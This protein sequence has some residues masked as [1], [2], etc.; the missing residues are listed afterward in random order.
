[1]NIRGIYVDP[2][3]NVWFSSYFSHKIGRLD[4]K[5]GDFKYYEPPTANAT[6]YGWVRDRK[7][8]YLWYADQNGNNISR[9]DPKSGQFVEYPIPTR[10]ANPRFIDI[11]GQGRIWFTEFMQS[12]IGML[13]PAGAKQIA[14][15]H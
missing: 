6:P 1:V 4:T 7:T 8:G 13:D 14:A 2:E 12:K 9:L 11:D 10:N 15:A 5:T 3:N